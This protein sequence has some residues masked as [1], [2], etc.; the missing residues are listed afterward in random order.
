MEILP[1]SA[2]NV[3]PVR[4]WMFPP[5]LRC[6]PHISVMEPE[7]PPVATPDAITKPPEGV[8]DEREVPE[9]RTIVPETPA[10][11]AFPDR[12]TK[13][14]DPVN[15]APVTTESKPPAAADAPTLPPEDR[16]RRPPTP[17]NDV[18][19]TKLNEPAEPPVAAPTAISNRP[20]APLLVLPV[21]RVTDPETPVPDN[22]PVCAVKL[23]EPVLALPLNTEIDPLVPDDT[24][25]ATNTVPL[26]AVE[27]APELKITDPLLPVPPTS[28]VRKVIPPVDDAPELPAPPLTMSTWPPVNDASRD[29][30]ADM[31][32]IPPVALFVDPIVTLIEPAVPLDA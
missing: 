8:D 19:T 21:L 3:L 28:A 22:E 32:I 16:T 10:D 7:A 5:A 29:P 26:A 4:V 24:P 12:I 23:P 31:D 18:P 9:L 15:P 13:S 14:P 6:S 27:A 20:E 30:P 2:F 17:E 11:S 1:V 25:D